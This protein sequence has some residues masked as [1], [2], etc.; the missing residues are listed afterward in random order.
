MSHPESPMMRVCKSASEEVA[1]TVAAAPLLSSCHC[2][3]ARDWWAAEQTH[4]G[5]AWR[6]SWPPHAT[7]SVPV[8]PSSLP[9]K[10]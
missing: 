7:I 1:S 5:T 6:L 10:P 3:W 9:H 4:G 2:R 8:L